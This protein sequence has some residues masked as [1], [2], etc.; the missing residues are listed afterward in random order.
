VTTARGSLA[1]FK[2]ETVSPEVRQVEV[3]EL[4]QRRDGQAIEMLETIAD[5][6]TEIGRDA[7]I[8]LGD[9]ATTGAVAYLNSRLSD[10]SPTVLAAAVVSLARAAGTG[11]VDGVAGVLQRNHSR[12]D[13][14]EDRVCGACVKALALTQAPA[15]LPVLNLE[16]EATTNETFGYEYGSAVVQAMKDIGSV[17]ARPLLLGYAERLT[18]ERSRVLEHPL[19]V[20]YLDQKITEAKEAAAALLK[21]AAVVARPRSTDDDEN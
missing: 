20:R 2:D 4:A 8:S 15:A 18:Q 3:F 10:P 1:W 14:W 12:A 13:G 7:I 21:P 6:P 19:S 9:T 5:V 11:A 16:F 17:D